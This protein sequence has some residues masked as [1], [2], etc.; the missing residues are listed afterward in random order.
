MGD[1]PD[2]DSDASRTDPF[3]QHL[4]I[5]FESVSDGRSV[6]TMEVTEDH[7]NVNGT[8]HGGAIFS[9]ADATAGAALNSLWVEDTGVALEANISFL[10]AAERGDTV[11]C[12]AEVTD[13]RRKTAEITVAVEL[14]DGTKIASSRA[15]GY[16]I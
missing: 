3:G 11:V 9:L 6:A 14:E 8:L 10:A 12:R 15:R 13:E 7:L 2:N 16:K 5:S 1:D 4:G